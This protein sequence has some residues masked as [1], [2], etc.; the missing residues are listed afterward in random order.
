MSASFPRTLRALQSDGMNPT[1]LGLTL[2]TAV[3]AFWACWLVLG[4]VSVYEI[5]A[6]AR[7]EAERVHPVAATVGGRIVA[8]HLSLAREVRSGDVLLEIESDRERLE[9]IEQ[10]RRLAALS[11]QLAVFE[12]QI[13]AEEEAISLAS[14]AARASLSE[15]TARL[16]VTQA[17]AQQAAEQLGRFRQLR[18]EGLVAEADLARAAHEAEGRRAEVVAARLGVER[19]SAEQV[20]AER[21]RRAH[22]GALVR[23]RLTLE[24]ER[25]AAAAAVTWR[26]REA[27]ERQIRALVD[28]RLGEVAPLQ[29]GAVIREGD[30][31]ASVVQ[32]GQIKV[33]AEFLPPALGR[34]R[35]GQPARLRLDG[36]PWTQYGHIPATVQSVASETRE[37][38]VRVELAVHQSPASHVPLEHGLPGAVEVELERV[39]PVTL[40][41]RTLGYALMRTGASPQPDGHPEHGGHPDQSAAPGHS[42]P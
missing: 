20:A 13:P 34:V 10:Q 41:I 29:V 27:E 11:S 12:T 2:I 25:A 15:A 19:L 39:A 16:A 4:R 21:E 7:L 36:F 32:Q 35:A 5:S 24:G 38:R 28:G 23:E 26:E 18:E 1:L 22:L 31:L 8:S 37:G 33:V 14:R 3:I 17:S 6:T 9:T 30:R 42:T 40:L